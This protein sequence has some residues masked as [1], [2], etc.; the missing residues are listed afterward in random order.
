MIYFFLFGTSMSIDILSFKKTNIS[1]FNETA[2]DIF[3]LWFLCFIRLVSTNNC[4]IMRD[5]VANILEA[6]SKEETSGSL[7]DLNIRPINV[8]NKCCGH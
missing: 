6:F 1:F 7:P 4:L 3:F 5:I 2:S 8:Q